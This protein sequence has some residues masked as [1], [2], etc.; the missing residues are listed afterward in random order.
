MITARSRRFLICLALAA[1]F[2]GS[3]LG[4]SVSAGAKRVTYYY[5]TQYF[6]GK[7]VSLAPIWKQ[8]SRKTHKPITTDVMVA[9]FH[10]GYNTNG[11]PYIH[12]NDN[13]PG[14]P[15][16]KVM[17][18][19]V[20]TL[21]QRGV[22]VRMMLGGAAQ[23]SYQ[24]LFS[25][26]KT[27][28]PILKHTLRHYKLDGI[29]L[30]IEETVALS[31]AQ[32]LIDQLNKDF[33]KK[34]IMTMA[35]VASALWGGSNLSGFSYLD[36][37]KSPEGK[38]INWFN[39]QFYSGFATL[40][41]PTDYEHAAQYFPPDKIVAGMLS[42]PLDGS[43]FVEIPQ[44]EKTLR[45]LVAKYPHFGGVSA[46]E[47]FNSLPGGLADPVKWGALMAKAMGK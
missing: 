26:W 19:E 5:Q 7:Y 40:Q 3:A 34:F 39:G 44:V 9:A 10:L 32:K 45:T 41:T 24:D 27:F 16:F 8:V 20:A 1:I 35:P 25:Q 43:G 13:V 31:D 42:N 23:G 2:A 11:T 12:L 21:Q 18:K 46:W 37:Y 15:M 6:N 36:L 22:T 17:W 28:Y 30:D 47:Y 38:R 29:D 33:G 4:E 14:D